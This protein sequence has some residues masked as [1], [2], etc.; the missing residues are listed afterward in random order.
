MFETEFSI[1]DFD[2]QMP[3]DLL[4][5]ETLRQI[6][7]EDSVIG[8][9]KNFLEIFHH[10]HKILQQRRET[11]DD[12]IDLDAADKDIELVDSFYKRVI[13]ELHN[14]PGIMLDVTDGNFDRITFNH[15]YSALIP[16]L[17]EHIISYVTCC[18]LWNKQMF[19]Q[20]YDSDT[21]GNNT[22]KQARKQFK[23]KT[24]ATI[25]IHLDNIIWCIL[26]DDNFLKPDNMINVL[27]KSDPEDYEYTVIANYYNICALQ[28][29][30][31]RW[32]QY[33][34]NIYTNI[35]NLQ[36]L[37]LSVIERILPTFP[38]R[39]ANENTEE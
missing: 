31:P 26:S 16:H 38:Q 14:V 39:T 36:S 18:I 9:R 33:I 19:V 30:V 17:H 13:E 25:M 37:R 21:L 24:D 27:Y 5:S 2:L 1:T 29:D 10:K 15:L 7:S 12:D 4:L 11:E 20:Q 35:E 32:L 3:D 23:N 6:R 34:R 22:V 8:S 28:F